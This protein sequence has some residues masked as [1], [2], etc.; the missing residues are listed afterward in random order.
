MSQDS[1][2]P[3]RLDPMQTMPAP[4]A[5][6][7]PRPARSSGPDGLGRW[8]AGGAVVLLLLAAARELVR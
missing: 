1:T 2:I 6:D 8:I 5:G 7:S 3:S 4:L